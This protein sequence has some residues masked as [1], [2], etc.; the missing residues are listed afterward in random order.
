MRPRA[1]VMVYKI[2]WSWIVGLHMTTNRHHLAV[3][4]NNT[5][6]V[7]ACVVICRGTEPL[8]HQNRGDVDVT[9]NN[10]VR[11]EPSIHMLSWGSMVLPL[12]AVM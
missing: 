9:Q 12:P 7:N 1:L 3:T 5:S 4:G 6:L 10:L 2:P 8:Q 11:I